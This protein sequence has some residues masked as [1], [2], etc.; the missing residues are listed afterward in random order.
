[1]RDKKGRKRRSVR[2]AF[3][4]RWQRRDVRTLRVEGN[5]A[6]SVV[7]SAE[8][9]ELKTGRKGLATGGRSLRN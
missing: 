4:K 7:L 9:M 3:L 5:E 6:R 8:E 2:R 1:M